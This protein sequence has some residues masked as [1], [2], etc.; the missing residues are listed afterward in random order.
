MITAV[1]Q[2]N[3]PKIPALPG[4]GHFAGPL[5]HSARWPA[6]LDVT[7]KRVAIVGTGASAMQIVPAIA[8]RVAHVTVFQRSPQWV[9]PNDVYFS[10]IDDAARC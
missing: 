8:E 9:A 5:F 7:G 10:P 2:L 1:G 3:R 4:P 6:D